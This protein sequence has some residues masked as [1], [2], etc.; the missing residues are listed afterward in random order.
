MSSLTFPTSP[1]SLR[2]AVHYTYSLLRIWI[3]LFLSTLETTIVST[4][5][6]AIA[7]SLS[8]F[9]ERNWVVT[10]YFLTYTGMVSPYTVE[11]KTGSIG[12]ANST[13]KPTPGFLVIYAKLASIFGPKAMFLLALCLF[14]VFSIACGSVSTMTQL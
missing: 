3:A 7:D 10:A 8:G 12:F 1:K 13:T 6:L 14:T 5:L 11:K 2:Y 9:E 4:S